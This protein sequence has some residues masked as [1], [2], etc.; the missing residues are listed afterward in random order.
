VLL[1]DGFG[2]VDVSVALSSSGRGVVFDA[3]GLAGGGARGAVVAVS[4]GL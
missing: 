3:R 1:F 4:E 2:V